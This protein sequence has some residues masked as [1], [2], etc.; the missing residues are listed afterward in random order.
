[1]GRP[2][3]G[4]DRR[5]RRRVRAAGRPAGAGLLMPLAARWAR[6]ARRDLPERV[7]RLAREA[8]KASSFKT[9]SSFSRASTPGIS[10][11]ARR[12]MRGRSLGI[13]TLLC[14]LLLAPAVDPAG[15]DPGEP[16]F[17]CGIAR[18]VVHRGLVQ[19]GRIWRFSWHNATLRCFQALVTGGEWLYSRR[20]AV[21]GDARVSGPL[22][23]PGRRPDIRD[24]ALQ[25]WVMRSGD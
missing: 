8:A 21:T 14:D 17:R 18:H 2:G 13:L 5:R 22:G 11:L 1:M 16:G 6:V 25:G 20:F 15:K 4:A 24:P 7:S 3:G 10:A 12:M 19:A 9:P 23:M